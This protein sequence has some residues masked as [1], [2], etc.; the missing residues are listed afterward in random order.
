MTACEGGHLNVVKML[1]KKHARVDVYDEAGKAS[2]HIAAENGHLDIVEYLLRNSAFVNTK[3]KLGITPLH[4]AAMKGWTDIAS[5]LVE[6]YEAT[7]DSFSNAM[8]TPLHLAA[9]HGKLD[10]CELLLRMGAN[11]LATD[12][13][14]QTALHIAAECDNEAIV[15]LF[16]RVLSDKNP[17]KLA[18]SVDR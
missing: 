7:V 14:G 12:D 4:L 16:L 11:P 8:R 2:L 13:N 1:I 15:Q 10:V 3:N 5:L 18:D 17:L 9:Q 6:K